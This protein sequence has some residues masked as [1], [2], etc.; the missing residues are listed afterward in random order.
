ML[1]TL[2]MCLL[3]QSL[4]IAKHIVLF[5]QRKRISLP[6]H[7]VVR[8]YQLRCS[9][10]RAVVASAESRYHIAT[11]PACASF[12]STSLFTPL[13][14][15]IAQMDGIK[16]GGSVI[17]KPL[18]IGAYRPTPFFTRMVGVLYH[19]TTSLLL[20][21]LSQNLNEVPSMDCLSP[22]VPKRSTC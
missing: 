15:C 11:S 12:G 8:S 18:F 2:Q 7:F 19:T 13:L 22:E 17:P 14:P 1:T 6:I 20:E 10:G 9:T 21:I 5:N 3:E 4:P 16:G